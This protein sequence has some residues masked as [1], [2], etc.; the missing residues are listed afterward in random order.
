MP[1]NLSGATRL[2]IIVGDPIAQVRSPGGMTAAYAAR[3]VDAVVV[4]VQVAVAD[5]GAFLASADKIKNL[6]CI[7][8]T[9][10][11]KFSCFQH[12]ATTT[13]RAQIL[14]AVNLMRRRANG[15][16]HG[17]MVDGEGFF[18][19]AI[20][21][22]FKPRAK[23]ALLVGA[24]GAGSAIAL[25][26][27]DQGVAELAIHDGDE[28]RRDALIAR[29]QGRNSCKVIA[30]SDDPSGFDFIANATPSGMKPSD[31]LP[32]LVH[33]LRKDMFVG[34]VITKPKITPLIAAARALGCKTSTGDDMYE[35]SQKAMVDFLLFKETNQLA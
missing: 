6:D 8:V 24:G 20:N 30:G 29:L 5:L 12:C 3:G 21:Q 9:V 25:E 26:L 14:G 19:A 22:G 17:D 18:Q 32:I 23:R 31:A 33:R 11:H 4:P 1:L 15:S 34:C 13:K 35:A 16:W 7:M 27:I 10:P 28:A 2:H